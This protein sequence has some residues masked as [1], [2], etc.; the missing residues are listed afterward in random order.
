MGLSENIAHKVNRAPS[1]Y[2]FLHFQKKLGNNECYFS[3]RGMAVRHPIL[4]ISVLLVTIF[5]KQM[6]SSSAGH[7]SFLATLVA[8]HFTPVSESV[9]KR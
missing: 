9:S 5:Q 8:L 4:L 3:K 7:S 2:L 1:L 6:L